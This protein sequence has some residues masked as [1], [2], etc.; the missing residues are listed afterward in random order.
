MM[1]FPSVLGVLFEQMPWWWRTWRGGRRVSEVVWKREVYY[2]RFH[3]C[4]HM[5]KVWFSSHYLLQNTKHTISQSNLNQYASLYLRS[6]PGP[7]CYMPAKFT[8]V[9]PTTRRV[10][11]LGRQYGQ[12]CR[13]IG[14][15]LGLAPSTVSRIDHKYRGTKVWYYSTPKQ[16]KP[17]KLSKDDLRYAALILARGKAQNAREL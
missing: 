16:G 2:C 14:E 5:Q 12:S 4:C 6:K 3:N 13:A 10:I 11:V 7:L 1:A 9:S 17:K 8:H 15:E